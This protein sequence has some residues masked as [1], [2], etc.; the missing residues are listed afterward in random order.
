MSGTAQVRRAFE[1]E[2]L[3]VPLAAI[4]PGKKLDKSILKGAKFGRICASI[5][6]TGLV[7]P[8][9]VT[10]LAKGGFRLLDG[11]ARLVALKA[12]GFAEARCLVALDDEGFTY[13]KRISHLA[14]I[15]EHYMIIRAIEKGASE[16]RIAASL[17][18]DVAAIRK[19][20]TMLEGICPEVVDRLK[21][22]S[23]NLGVFFALR[24]MKP[25]RQIEVFELMSD[26]GN[27]TASY[28]RVLLAGTRQHDLVAPEKT[29][30]VVGLAPEQ[31]ERMQQEMESVQADFKTVE[32]TFGPNV[33]QLVVATG[34]IG[35]LLK[36]PQIERY[37]EEHHPEYLA[38]FR[39]IVRATSLDQNQAA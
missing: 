15:Q 39:S 1:D 22:T 18:L 9:V 16:E 29:R 3:L 24:R 10:R 13:N 31:M 23:V 37:L 32:K 5:K 20:R 25:L 7:E 33:L 11:H 19:R 21:S 6:E 30:K 38:Q 28:A 14:T 34:Y 26:A 35:S 4:E 12:A 17:N 36:N 2:A 8:L 27:L